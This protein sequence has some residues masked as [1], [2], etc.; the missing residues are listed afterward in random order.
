MF[1]L[2]VY[3]KNSLVCPIIIFVL[4]TNLQSNLHG[5]D[6]MK[7][8]FF[9]TLKMKI[10]FCRSMWVRPKTRL[11]GTMQE[12]PPPIINSII[13]GVVW[14]LGRL[15]KQCVREQQI[16]KSLNQSC[17]TPDCCELVTIHYHFTNFDNYLWRMP[18][19]AQKGWLWL[20]NAG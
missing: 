14:R 8:Q 11:H 3:K 13:K 20:I 10:H 1:F 6:L 9:I 5:I 15:T 7:R 16:Q 12:S 19:L 18:M 4:I 17:I 2:N